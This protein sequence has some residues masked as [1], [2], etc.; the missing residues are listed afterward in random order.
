MLTGSGRDG[1]LYSA[2]ATCQDWT[3]DDGSSANGKPRCGMAW[4]RGFGSQGAHWISEFSAPGCA[5]GVG[6]EGRPPP[7]SN[8]VGSGGGYGGFYCFALEP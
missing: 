5:P 8:Q 6:T 1:R 4:P 2:S 3:S 7:G